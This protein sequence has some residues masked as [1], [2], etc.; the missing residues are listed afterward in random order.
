[1]AFLCG[2]Q[3]VNSF[4]I[5]FKQACGMPPGEFR[6]QATLGRTPKPDDQTAAA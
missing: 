5:A 3:S 6:K 2:Y 1:M 4:F